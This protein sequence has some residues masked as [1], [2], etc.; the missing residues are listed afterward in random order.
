MEVATEPTVLATALAAQGS[1]AAVAEGTASAA[2]AAPPTAQ[3]ANAAYRLR[4]SAVVVV[5]MDNSLRFAN[6]YRP[7]KRC[8]R[9]QLV[10]DP[11]TAIRHLAIIAAD[12]P[13]S[14]SELP[15]QRIA[16]ALSGDS[17][18]PG[19][20]SGLGRV[21]AWPRPGDYGCCCCTLTRRRDGEKAGIGH[22]A[23]HDAPEQQPAQISLGCVRSVAASAGT[24]DIR[25]HDPV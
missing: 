23:V 16:S 15:G 4:R 11:E 14:P 19:R 22:P 10:P 7:R 5:F 13:S 21:T 18:H 20:P 2:T 24:G 25:Q 3:A 9:R 17:A 8:D 1:D 6:V 12:L